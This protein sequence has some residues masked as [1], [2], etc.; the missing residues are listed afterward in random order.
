MK[1][2]EGHI[3]GKRSLH[4]RQMPLLSTFLP[5]EW[6]SSIARFSGIRRYLEKYSWEWIKVRYS[7]RLST[8]DQWGGA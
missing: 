1:K 5:Q 8:W 7:S 3:R 2:K 4:G 6:R